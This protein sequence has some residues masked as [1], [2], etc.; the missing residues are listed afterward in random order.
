M[1]NMPGKHMRG[2]ILV[3]NFEEEFILLRTLVSL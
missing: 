3:E 1:G 2:I